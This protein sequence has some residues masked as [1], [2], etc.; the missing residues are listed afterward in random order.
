MYGTPSG[1]FMMCSARW[2]CCSAPTPETPTRATASLDLGSSLAL[3]ASSRSMRAP[4]SA[5]TSSTASTSSASV[6]WLTM[7]A[8][9]T[10]RPSEHRVRDVDAAVELELGHEPL[11]Q[12]RQILLV[13]RAARRHVAEAADRQPDR[14]GQ[15]EL[16]PLLDAGADVARQLG[17]V[18][19]ARA[20]GPACRARAAT[21]TPSAPGSRGCTA[22]PARRS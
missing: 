1:H 7:H 21:P 16:R 20:V 14:R 13:A 18:G 3:S 10:N 9:S 19:D 22:A 2:P 6:R 8:R 11:V 15:L 5:T 12:P 4:S 17:I